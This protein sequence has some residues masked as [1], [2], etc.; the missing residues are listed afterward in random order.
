[1]ECDGGLSLIL[2]IFGLLRHTNHFSGVLIL[3]DDMLF[4]QQGVYY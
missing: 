1:M 2:E 3:L 4:R